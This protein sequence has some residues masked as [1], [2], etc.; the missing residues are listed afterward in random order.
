[1]WHENT[2][3]SESLATFHGSL[4][5]RAQ[6]LALFR[7]LLTAE[8]T[9]VSVVRLQLSSLKPLA[10][11]A[12][13]KLCPTEFLPFHF[14]IASLAQKAQTKNRKTINICTS[15]CKQVP[16]PDLKNI[17]KLQFKKIE[18]K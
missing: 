16:S 8:F 4:G 10:S 15:R 2:I 3:L 9:F 11:L 14:P 18:N 7:S 17:K 1:M 13:K 5:L 12:L 6:A